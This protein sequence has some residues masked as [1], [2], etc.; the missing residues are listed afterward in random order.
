MKHLGGF[1]NRVRWIIG[2]WQKEW[3]P[4]KCFPF[5]SVCSVKKAFWTCQFHF[6]GGKFFGCFVDPPEHK[7]F[8][9]LAAEKNR[10]KVRHQQVRLQRVFRQA[11]LAK[12][13]DRW[14]PESNSKKVPIKRRPKPKMKGWL[15]NTTINKVRLA[16]AVT[17][18][19]Y[20]FWDVLQLPGRVWFVLKKISWSPKATAH[21]S[22]A[23]NLA[24]MIFL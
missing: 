22:C 24:P 8:T 3:N 7:N 10:W 12:G 5:I 21:T 2:T 6:L 18:S 23:E 9:F 11:R 19:G 4:L 14:I 1:K 13:G 15:P 20:V 16:F 17:I